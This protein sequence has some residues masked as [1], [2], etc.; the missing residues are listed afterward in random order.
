MI[1]FRGLDGKEYKLDIS[2]NKHPMRTKNSC[3]SKIQYDCGQFLKSQHKFTPILE[4]LYIPGHDFYFDFFI[5]SIKLAI[6]IDGRQ[7]D[8][9]VPY[10]HKNKQ[11]FIKAKE[12]DDSKY[13]LCKINDWEF[14]RVSSLEELKKH[15]E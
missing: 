14:I 8:E 6:E 11:N 13:E 4:E 15:Y 2:P 7:H 3:K 10:F 1:K 9:Y 5:P 12:R